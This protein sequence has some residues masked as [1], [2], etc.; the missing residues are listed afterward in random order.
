M[1]KLR[2]ILEMKDFSFFGFLDFFIINFFVMYGLQA[3]IEH[4]S[5]EAIWMED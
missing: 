2:N 5:P 1:A 4:F 3:W